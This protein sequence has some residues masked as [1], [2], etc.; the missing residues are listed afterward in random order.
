M[1]AQ[2]RPARI[3]SFKRL[4]AEVHLGLDLGEPAPRRGAEMLHRVGLH[5]LAVVVP[6]AVGDLVPK[7][8][9]RGIKRPSGIPH[10]GHGVGA[11]TKRTMDALAP[12]PPS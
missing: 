7:P 1:K 6:V 11:P 3:R 5:E 8:T 9:R 12:A 10:S 2:R 4:L